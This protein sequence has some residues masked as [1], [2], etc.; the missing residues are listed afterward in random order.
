MEQI[1]KPIKET[2]RPARYRTHLYWTRKPPDLAARFVEAYTTPGEKILDPFCGSGV[3]PIEAARLGRV[4]IGFDIDPV[5]LFIGRMTALRTDLSRVK[6]FFKLF[7]RKI[8]LQVMSLYRTSCPLCSS[9][10]I[11]ARVAVWLC[12]DSF[13]LEIRGNC[14]S[15]GDFSK[16]PDKKD[17][18]ILRDL[19]KKPLSPSI[20]SNSL[21][22]KN[23]TPFLKAEGHCSIKD[24][25][26]HRNL[27]AL[28]II[29]EQIKSIPEKND[30][31]ILLFAFSSITHLAS[32]LTPDRKSRPYSSHWGRPSYWVPQRSQERNVFELLS[33]ALLGRQGVL[34]GLKDSEENLKD[35]IA[36]SSLA[37]A[38]YGSLLLKEASALQLSKVLPPSS[39]DLVI[40]DPPYG[41][42]IQ[43]FELNSLWAAWLGFERDSSDEVIINPRQNKSQTIFG[44]M[45]QTAFEEIFAVLKP[46]KKMILT[47][48][49]T[50]LRVWALLVQGAVAA[51]FSLD[52]LF[53]QPPRRISFKAL[54]QPLNAAVGDYVFQFS[55]QV[56]VGRPGIPVN[57]V[58]DSFPEFIREKAIKTIHTL[59]RPCTFTELL[60]R[61][62]PE[63]IRSDLL[64]SNDLDNLQSVLKQ[65]LGNGLWLVKGIDSIGKKETDLWWVEE[66]SPL[67][68]RN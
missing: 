41:G 8:R 4:G 17:Q 48:H 51:G 38:K 61:I 5:G 11:F 31:D 37:E 6:D 14:P 33:N 12:E 64:F 2:S 22:Y 50:D 47:F 56:G 34:K 13:P 19:Q 58:K 60:T 57:R 26:T 9:P 25:Y 66:E 68:E 49:S 35:I 27:L 20:P 40:T 28:G 46:G 63:I 44:K 10:D 15:C 3:I 59:G 16:Q 53:H 45:L 18:A 32:R 43:H 36:I 54:A 62:Y 1:L 55:R 24:L 65:W 21:K 29:L 39:I 30:R 7:L 42:S 23:G 67:F 52:H